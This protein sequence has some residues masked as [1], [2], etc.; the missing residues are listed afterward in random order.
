MSDPP[1]YPLCQGISVHSNTG[2]AQSCNAVVQQDLTQDS[3]FMLQ[4][5]R[6]NLYCS[7]KALS[8]FNFL[9]LKAE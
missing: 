1:P 9:F 5:V 2:G 3:S 6:S 8:P 7:N 4:G